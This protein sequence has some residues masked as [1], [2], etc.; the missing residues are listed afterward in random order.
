MAWLI[1]PTSVSD[2][3]P[4]IYMHIII[5]CL[6]EQKE[7][8]LIAL[9]SVAPQQQE[10]VSVCARCCWD[11]GRWRYSYFWCLASTSQQSSNTTI[12]KKA[13]SHKCRGKQQFNIHAIFLQFNNAPLRTEVTFLSQT[14]IQWAW[15]QRHIYLTLAISSFVLKS[16]IIKMNLRSRNDFRLSCQDRSREQNLCS[17]NN[18]RSPALEFRQGRFHTN[19]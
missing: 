15:I 3:V 7:K 6:R 10:C 19:S 4:S 9:S 17:Q 1:T 18:T 16:W 13:C 8:Q 5:I 12:I 11:V 14:R 2:T